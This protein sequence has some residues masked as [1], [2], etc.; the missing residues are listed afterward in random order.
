M[1]VL[2]ISAVLQNAIKKNIPYTYEDGLV[3]MNM[4]SFY[5][6]IKNFDSEKGYIHFEELIELLVS[7]YITPN[8]TFN[9]GFNLF[10]LKDASIKW[11]IPVIIHKS[12]FDGKDYSAIEFL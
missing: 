7:E 2:I 12:S 1:R 8:K 10:F 9:E 3:L 11:I 6:A 5:K 4:T